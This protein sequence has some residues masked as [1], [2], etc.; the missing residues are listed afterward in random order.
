MFFRTSFLYFI[1]DGSIQFSI[2]KT[3]AQETFHRILER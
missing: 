1:L 3:A 2:Y